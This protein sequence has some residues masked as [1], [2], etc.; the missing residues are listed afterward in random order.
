MKKKII[1]T[2]LLSVFAL[3]LFAYGEIGVQLE[4]RNPPP[5]PPPPQHHHEYEENDSVLSE[6]FAL[7]WLANNIFLTFDDYPYADGKYLNFFSK[8]TI[9]S[10]NDSVAVDENL[11]ESEPKEQFYR[12]VLETGIIAFPSKLIIGNETR[13][14]G[15]I[16]KFFGPVF[17]NI[18][19]ANN[20]FSD[21]Q[22]FYLRGNL[23]LGGQLSIMHANYCDVSFFVQWLHWYG[24]ERFNGVGCGIIIR[25]YPAKPIL[26]EYRL[27]FQNF[28][29]N[30]ENFFFEAHIELGIELNSPYEI[31]AAWKLTQD[32]LF[33]Q[34]R[35]YGFSLGVKYNF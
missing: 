20:L 29:K 30:P 6:M 3:N 26:F 32:N 27:S 15:Y 16:W 1:L 23:K 8:E 17:E 14:E 4:K 2:I 35:M 33:I 22:N 19:Y 18:L 21:Y 5:P 34:G 9:N 7:L 10:M 12:F 13:F 11:S 28:F 24:Q 31:Y 25:S